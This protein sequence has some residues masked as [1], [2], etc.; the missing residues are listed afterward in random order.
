MEPFEWGLPSIQIDVSGFSMAKDFQTGKFAVEQF[1]IDS[2]FANFGQVQSDPNC[3]PL[4]A[5]GRSPLFY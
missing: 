2:D 1:K 3:P 4:L 5:L